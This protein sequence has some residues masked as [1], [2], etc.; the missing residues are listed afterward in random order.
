M[1]RRPFAMRSPRF[2]SF[3][4]VAFLP[5]CI[6]IACAPPRVESNDTPASREANPD[7]VGAFTITGDPEAEAGA[8]WAFRGTVGGVRYDLTGVLMKP[9][10]SGPFPAV[11]PSMSANNPV[12]I[13]F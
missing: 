13:S 6:A 5:A 9:R 10:G 11:V 4:V 1:D 12:W 7:T 3:L 8:A 2:T